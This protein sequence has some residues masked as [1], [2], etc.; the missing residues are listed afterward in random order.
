MLQK[1][2]AGS[3]SLAVQE[4]E[5]K[6]NLSEKEAYVMGLAWDTCHLVTKKEGGPLANGTP[7]IF[8]WG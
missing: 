4:E 7:D 8:E 6:N 1:Q 3:S 2:E 5:I